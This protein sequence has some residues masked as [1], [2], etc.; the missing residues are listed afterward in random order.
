MLRAPGFRCNFYL[1]T[2]WYC[3]PLLRLAKWA[4]GKLGHN[5]VSI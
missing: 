1:I 5:E 2:Y 3:Y 4:E